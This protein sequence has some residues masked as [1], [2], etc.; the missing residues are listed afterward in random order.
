VAEAR[1]RPDYEKLE[2]MG[3][4]VLL[5]TTAAMLARAVH[6]QDRHAEAAELCRTSERIAAPEDVAAQ[7]QWRGVL[8][9]IR[10]REGA[11]DV[12]EAL[13][14]EAV[15]L[16]EPTDMLVVRGDA[17]L[18]LAEVLRLAGRGGDA[19]AAARRGLE[20][21]E[22]KGNLVSAS[23]ARSWPVVWAPA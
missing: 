11:P 14:R 13:A 6:D 12:A 4:R 5:A 3:E 8:A 19:E 15:R 7:A 22:R 20:L 1:L 2:R 18:D 9:R 16:V 23:R 10:A 17:L 21:Y